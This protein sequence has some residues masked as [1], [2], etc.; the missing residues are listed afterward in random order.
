M[1]TDD[2]MAGSAVDHAQ[3]MDS[4]MAGGAMMN[5]HGPAS[6]TVPGARE[7]TVSASSFRFAPEEIRIRTGEDVTIVLAASDIAHDFI[8][9]EL[10]VHVAAAPGQAG[11]GGLHAPSVPGRYTAYCSVPGHR[12]AGMTATV[13]VDTA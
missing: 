11:R 7:V 5:D 1:M 8:I 2:Q 4:S 6:A 10:D 12:E 13:V 9:D 3:M